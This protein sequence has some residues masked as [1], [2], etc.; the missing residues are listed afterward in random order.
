MVWRSK[1]RKIKQQTDVE[2]KA[3]VSRKLE[4]LS[5]L[6]GLRKNVWRI[7]VALEKLAGIESQDSKEEQFLWPESKGE[8]TEV[9]GNKEKGK[10]K[11]KRIDRAEKEEVRGQEEE[12]GIE[13][14]EEGSI[15]FSPVVYSVS[16]RNL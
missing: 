8:E 14:M 12:N 5:E 10:Q 9:Q 15:S 4:D 16:T 2:L 11:E 7:A 1:A 6:R 13:G 3:E